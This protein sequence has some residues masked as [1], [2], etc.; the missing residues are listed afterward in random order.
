MPTHI[1]L[2]RGV[3]VGG[4]RKIAMADFR[5]F[6]GDIGL[7]NGATLLQS[8]NAVFDG[9]RKSAAALEAL[10]RTEAQKRLGL[11]T[12][13]FVYD[14]DAWQRAIAANPLRVEAKQDPARMIVWFLRD[15]PDAARA[16]T[17]HDGVPGS[18]IYRVVGR[19]MYTFYP[20]GM[21]RSR[22]AG[23]LIERRLG[24]RGTARNWNTVL[25]L[26]AATTAS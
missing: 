5:A 16:R 15:A 20:D 9:G 26:A 17:L 14:A 25:K 21:G 8:G 24:T 2:L 23:A 3:N 22:F 19:Q 4:Y 7:K 13:F 12:D 1:A 10:L 11:D 18:E 6:L